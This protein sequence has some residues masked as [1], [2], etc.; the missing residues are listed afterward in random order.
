MRIGQIK[1]MKNLIKRND[2]SVIGPLL[3]IVV[4]L[5][6]IYKLIKFMSSEDEFWNYY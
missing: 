4:F 2:M 6:V 1:F 3:I 5:G